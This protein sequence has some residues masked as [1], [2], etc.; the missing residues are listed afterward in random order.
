MNSPERVKRAH[1][2]IYRLER[3]SADSSWA[4]R[5]GGLKVALLRYLEALESG[6][7]APA[8]ENLLQEAHA[9]LTAAAR[10]IPDT[11]DTPIPQN[12]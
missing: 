10:E 2:L 9:L 11:E 6:E 3:L 7:P 4:H 12:H 8:L 1:L 5:A